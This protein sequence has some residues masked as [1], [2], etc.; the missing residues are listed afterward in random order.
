[1]LASVLASALASV[2]VSA[3][4]FRLLPAQV[5]VLAQSYFSPIAWLAFMYRLA[6]L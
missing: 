3:L 5:I 1:M 2:L 4:A 6:E